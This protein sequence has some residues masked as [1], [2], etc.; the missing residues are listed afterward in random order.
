MQNYIL[1]FKNMLFVKRKKKTKT[2][3]K[4][5]KNT[6]TAWKTIFS[7]LWNSAAVTIEVPHHRQ[8][9]R[10]VQNFQIP[11]IS[12]WWNVFQSVFWGLWKSRQMMISIIIFNSTLPCGVWYECRLPCR[13]WNCS[14]SRKRLSWSMACLQ[15]NIDKVLICRVFVFISLWR[16]F[17]LDIVPPSPWIIFHW[18]ASYQPF[19]FVTFEVKYNI[20]F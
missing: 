16:C 1:F 14:D 19:T 18:L 6:K 10:N 20:L 12:S 11:D 2:K 8:L 3:T 17:V 4:Q 13:G 9:C 7:L 5:K 15:N